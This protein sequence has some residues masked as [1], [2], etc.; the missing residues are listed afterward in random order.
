MKK[1]G[2]YQTLFN[3]R[4]LR[5]LLSLSAKGYFIQTGW[6]LSYKKKQALALDNS[7]I[8]WLTYSF[9]DFLD[10]RLKANMRLFEY[11]AG[12]S[13]L[14]FSKI[15]NFVRSIEH[16]KAWYEQVKASFAENVHISLLPLT[17][18]V[19]EKAILAEEGYFDIILIDGR[20]R[21][22]CIKNAIQKLSPQGVIILDDSERTKYGEAFTFMHTEGFKQLPFSG[23]AIGA[24]HRK[25]TTV[26]Y[27]S[28]NIL[29]I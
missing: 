3:A 2:S 7:P 10:G 15:V 12:N 8:P 17:N 13:T 27:R 26:F 4:I 24:I 21:V 6:L 16:D 28:N 11:G 14:Y 1:Q 5:G 25:C 19:Y 20:N 9:L 23:I 22:A 18:Q 29:N